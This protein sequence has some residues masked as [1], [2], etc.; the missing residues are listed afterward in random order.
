MR[1]L[2]DFLLAEAKEEKDK[3]PKPAKP[4]SIPKMYETNWDSLGTGL[5]PG[6]LTDELKNLLAVDSAKGLK[7][8]S[9]VNNIKARVKPSEFLKDLGIEKK[10]DFFEVMG[11]IRKSANDFSQFFENKPPGR[12]MIE[13]NTGSNKEKVIHL[14]ISPLGMRVLSKDNQLIRFYKFWIDSIVYAAMGQKG[15][16]LSSKLKYKIRANELYVRCPE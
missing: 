6:P 5:P 15:V 1:T 13:S 11:Q 7:I 4:T 16:K 12:F 2:R 9:D 14:T 10:D 3:Q 8:S